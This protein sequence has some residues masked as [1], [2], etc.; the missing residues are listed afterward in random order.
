MR[1]N[2]SSQFASQAL[3]TVSAPPKDSQGQ[4]NRCS[5]RDAVKNVLALT[6]GQV[7]KL[8]RRLPTKANREAAARRK[9]Q[10]FLERRRRD[11][12]GEASSLCL[13]KAFEQQRHQEQEGEAWWCAWAM[14]FEERRRQDQKGEAWW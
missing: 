2:P 1:Y 6:A 14:T 8:L 12:H 9:T 7:K 11:Q 13:R 5:G 4:Q 10:A 3:T